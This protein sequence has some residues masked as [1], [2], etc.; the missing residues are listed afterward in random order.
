MRTKDKWLESLIVLTAFVTLACLPPATGET[1]QG[2]LKVFIL[3]GQSNMEGH[4]VANTLD[5]LGSGKMMFQMGHAFGEG[6][7]ELLKK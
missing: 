7:I 3:A 6:M 1:A 5:Y 4:A 2:P